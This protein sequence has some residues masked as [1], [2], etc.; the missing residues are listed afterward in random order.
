MSEVAAASEEQAA[1]VEEVTATVNEF[2]GMI[3]KTA[4]ESV[5]LA[6]ASEESSSAIGQINRWYLR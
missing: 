4:Q 3:Q 5:D 6:T 1:S 2:S